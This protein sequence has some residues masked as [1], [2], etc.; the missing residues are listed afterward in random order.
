ME[1]KEEDEMSQVSEK[2]NEVQMSKVGLV[3]KEKRVNKRPNKKTEKEKDTDSFSLEVYLKRVKENKRLKKEKNDLK[4]IKVKVVCRQP[5]SI[6]FHKD[7]DP[8]KSLL[9][10]L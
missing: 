4:L 3:N 10:E 5:Y 9:T 1:E 2:R 6:S 7:F 8:V